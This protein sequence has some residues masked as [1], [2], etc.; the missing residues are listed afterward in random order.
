MVAKNDAAHAGL[1]AQLKARRIKK[2]YIALVQGNDIL[3]ALSQQRPDD[4][5]AAG[6]A[7]SL[8]RLAP[9]FHPSI[10]GTGRQNYSRRAMIQSIKKPTL[11]RSASCS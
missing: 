9:C 6:N 5:P 2:A 3:G 7:A 4:G 8:Q 10:D 1:A 11:E